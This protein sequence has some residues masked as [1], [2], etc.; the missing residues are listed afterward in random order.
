MIKIISTL[1]NSILSNI[2]IMYAKIQST[3]ITPMNKYKSNQMN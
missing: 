2:F 1:I 3:K